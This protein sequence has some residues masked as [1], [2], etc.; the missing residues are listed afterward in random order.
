M[1][2]IGTVVLRKNA[3]M[4]EDL[5]TVKSMGQ[6]IYVF[7]FCFLFKPLSGCRI[8]DPHN[9]ECKRRILRT[10]SCTVTVKHV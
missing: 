10:K 5:E 8:R 9:I 6:I 3:N 1:T 7:I 4:V 2:K